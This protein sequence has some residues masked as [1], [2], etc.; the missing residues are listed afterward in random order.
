MSCQPLIV[1][2]WRQRDA[3]PKH[4][5]AA[6]VVRAVVASAA[7]GF[8]GDYFVGM[9]GTVRREEP[10]MNDWL[11]QSTGHIQIQRFVPISRVLE[12]LLSSTL[13]RAQEKK[14]KKDDDYPCCC[15]QRQKKVA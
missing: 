9:N 11:R 2:V 13:S 3:D 6:V 14:K 1:G 4:D 12:I 7:A 15:S 8:D 5:D 10:M